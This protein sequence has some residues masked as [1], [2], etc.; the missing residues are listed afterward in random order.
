MPITDAI[1]ELHTEHEIFFLLTAYVETL[2]FCDKLGLLPWQMRDLPLAGLDDV[3]AR[4]EGLRLQL[5]EMV[6]NADR[7]ASLIIEETIQVF[8]TALRRLAFLQAGGDLPRA[9]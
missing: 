3:E 2:R 4:I 5:R 8:D 1:Q 6:S 9:A 7:R